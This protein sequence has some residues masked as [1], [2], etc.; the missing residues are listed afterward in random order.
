[1]SS[2]NFPVTIDELGADLEFHDINRGETIRVDNVTIRT[3]LLNH[4]GG[5]LGFRIEYKG[6][7]VTYASDTEYVDGPDRT[8]IDLACGNGHSDHGLDVQDPSNTTGSLTVCPGAP[9]ATAPGTRRWNW[10]LPPARGSW[11]CSITATRTGRSRRSPTKPGTGS[12]LHLQR[13]KDSRSSCRR[14]YCA[15]R[16]PPV[17]GGSGVPGCPTSERNCNHD[18]ERHGG[19]ASLER[20]WMRFPSEQEKN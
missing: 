11:Y 1:M 4:P 20:E 19:P 12:L 8:V 5:S 17:V 14:A 6:R 2:P 15:T 9:G 13:T 3:A 18:N 16:Q 7:S 10:P